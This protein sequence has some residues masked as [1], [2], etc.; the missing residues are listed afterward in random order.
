LAEPLDLAD[1]GFSLVGV[2]GDGVDGDVGGGG[3]EDE[4]D[5]LAVAVPAGQGEYAGAVGLWPGLLGDDAAVS[6]PLVELRE[7]YVGT[8]DLVA[9]GGKFSPIGPR[10]VPRLM[11]YFRSLAACGWS[12]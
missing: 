2:G 9:R 11:A 5:R 10:S 6:G 4:G 1:V 12:E 3:I 7:Y 8:V